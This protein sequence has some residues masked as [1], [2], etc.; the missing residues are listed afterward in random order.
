MREQEVPTREKPGPGRG[1]GFVVHP[2]WGWGP[3]D[4]PEETEQECQAVLAVTCGPGRDTGAEG[5]GARPGH[6]PE[7]S[8]QGEQVGFGRSE[9]ALGAPV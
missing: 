1:A 2:E 7:G 4:P 5:A 3:P 8:T 9:G 6:M